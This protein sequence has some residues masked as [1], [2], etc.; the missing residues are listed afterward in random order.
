VEVLLLTL[1]AFLAGLVDSVAGGGGLISLPALFV[2]GVSPHLALGTNKF[3][4]C[5]GTS[6][7][8]TRYLRGGHLDPPTGFAAAAGALIGAFL[9]ARAAL[10]LPGQFLMR[11][12]PFLVVAVGAFTFLR[13]QFGMV[14][15]YRGRTGT[16]LAAAAV[17]GLCLGTYDGFFGPGTGTF[18]AFFF[19][20][21]FRFGFLRATAHAKLANLASN[22]GALATFALYHQVMWPLA[23]PMAL[24]NI[25]GSWLGAGLAIRRGAALI[26]PLFGL[27]LVGL[28]IRLIFFT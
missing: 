1:A 28:L 8:A 6:F 25:I 9:G 4:S 14:D 19:V 2:A 10:A 18:L 20:I 22:I 5:L 16:G 12:M 15:S 11:L 3:Q 17:L 13:P 21:L 26:K 24:A 27:V 23:I 7:S